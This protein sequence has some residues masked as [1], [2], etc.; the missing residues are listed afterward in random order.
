MN[1][2][3][4][5]LQRL[6]NGHDLTEQEAAD[7][8]LALTASGGSQALSGAVLAALVSKGRPRRRSADSRGPCGIK[9]YVPT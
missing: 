9:P 8:F 5:T 3:P 7:V 4:R 1:G 6:T 2:M